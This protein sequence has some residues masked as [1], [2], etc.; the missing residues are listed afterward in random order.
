MEQGS[1]QAFHYTRKTHEILFHPHHD[2]FSIK[3]T[4]ALS[5]Y[6]GY[7]WKVFLNS[8][9]G[10]YVN[11][12]VVPQTKLKPDDFKVMFFIAMS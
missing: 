8:M 4:P 7:E 9:R 2:G 5:N 1:K 3:F 10:N 6:L 12:Q 11:S